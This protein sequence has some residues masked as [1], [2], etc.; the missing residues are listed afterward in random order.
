MPDKDLH[1]LPSLSS[2]YFI[3]GVA[4]SNSSRKTTGFQG[5]L[6]SFLHVG[7]HINSPIPVRHPIVHSVDNYFST[8]DA[9]WCS[10]QHS[11]LIYSESLGNVC[12]P[13]LPY[14]HGVGCLSRSPQSSICNNRPY[15]LVI[16]IL[17]YP[18]K[19]GLPINKLICDLSFHFSF[20]ANLA[21]MGYSRDGTCI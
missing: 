8:C 5:S 15:W 17:V 14:L 10:Q 11:I 6:I 2:A 9:T 7:V 4:H 1:L 18:A 16:Q 21:A 13:G 12:F 19:V 20:F 3:P